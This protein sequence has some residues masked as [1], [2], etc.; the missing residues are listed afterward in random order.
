MSDNPT[1]NKAGEQPKVSLFSPPPAKPAE[2][3]VQEFAPEADQFGRYRVRDLDTGHVLTVGAAGLAHGRFEVLDE[4][5][6]DVSGDA[7]PP[8]HNR[9]PVEPI[10][11]EEQANG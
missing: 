7:L 2:P 11:S 10:E 9:F 1:E 4:A 3:A 6:S 5:A 8:E